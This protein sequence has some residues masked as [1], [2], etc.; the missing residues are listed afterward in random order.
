MLN[1]RLEQQ[2]A[3]LVEADKLKN[4]LRRTA[5]VD[6]SRLENSAEHSWHL[7][8]AALVM[9]EYVVGDCDVLR[10]IELMAIHDLVEID[11]GDTF[12]Y[13]TA[14]QATKAIREVAAADRIF[15]LLPS[16]QATYFR[17]LW[18]EFE[19]QETSESRF[20]NALDRFQPLL[21]N[22][23]SGGGSWRTHSLTRAQVL[24]RM[25]P[26]E[27]ALPRLWPT[28]LKIVDSYC[29]TGLLRGAVDAESG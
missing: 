17:A 7:V 20:A 13:D 22:A 28:V 16:E 21:Q 23:Y 26:V 8:L 15:S 5:L 6:S 12:A 10:A 29:A 27:T 11:A 24:Q 14:G 3:F 1:D 2:I 4:V 25:A 19:A 18:E 9:R